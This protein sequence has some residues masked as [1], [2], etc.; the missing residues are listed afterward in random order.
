MAGAL[1]REGLRLSSLIELGSLESSAPVN[2][3]D[4]AGLLAFAGRSAAPFIA[5]AARG[6][7]NA[8]STQT[9]RQGLEQGMAALLELCNA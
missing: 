2:A 4:A 6:R 3:A 8:N 9:A 1:E 7:V 5:E